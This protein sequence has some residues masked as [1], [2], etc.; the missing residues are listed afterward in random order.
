MPPRHRDRFL[1]HKR[2]DQT[3]IVVNYTTGGR[4]PDHALP[5][6]WETTRSV[7]HSGNVASRPPVPKHYTHPRRHAVFMFIFFSTPLRLERYR[8]LFV[9][10]P[11]NR[12]RRRFSLRDA[13]VGGFIIYIIIYYLLSG[14]NNLTFVWM[15]FRRRV[16][17]IV[18]ASCRFMFT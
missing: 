4:S 17:C 8:V 10:V 3:T 2:H 16:R 7:T 18:Y 9:D 6:K 5:S 11:L 1:R 14:R 13:E 15:Y 12:R